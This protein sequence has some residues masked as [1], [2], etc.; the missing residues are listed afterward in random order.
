MI[1]TQVELASLGILTNQ[2]RDVAMTEH[3]PP[4]VLMGR[5]AR[6]S[7]VIMT[8]GNMSV[9]IGEG[10]RTKV[11][12]NPGTSSATCD[13]S[14]EVKKAIIAEKYGADTISDLS[15][16][17]DID[18]IRREIFKTSRLPVTTVP[19]YQATAEQGIKKLPVCSLQE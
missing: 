14:E 1:Q 5:V 9:G 11:N 18:R 12:V 19:I 10:L 6:G 3:L 16:G 15:M 4:D 8:R 17:G 2:V 13:L 7:V